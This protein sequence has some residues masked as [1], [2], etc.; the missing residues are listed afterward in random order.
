MLNTP[1]ELGVTV[2]KRGIAEVQAGT[3]M[4]YDFSNIQNGSNV[5]L[6]EFYLHD[7][8]P[9][10]VVRLEKIWTGV[11]SER[12]MME[13]QIKTNLKTSYRTVRKNLLSTANNEIDCSQTALGLAGGEYVTE[14]RLVFGEVQ[15]GF[16]EVTGPKVQV[17][18]MDTVENGRKFTNK[19]DVGGWYIDKLIYDTDGW[20]C[21]SYNRPRGDLPKTGW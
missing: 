6:N 14:F 2:E 21:V 12:V 9:T 13:L 1:V 20:T 10:E 8:L 7:I 4:F 3:S 16:H 5:P 19:V 17:K 11:W 15:P 18:V